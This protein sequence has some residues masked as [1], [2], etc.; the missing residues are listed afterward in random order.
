MRVERGQRPGA[1]PLARSQVTLFC[2]MMPCMGKV[3]AQTAG[4]S[5]DSAKAIHWTTCACASL[6]LPPCSCSLAKENQAMALLSATQAPEDSKRRHLAQGNF[7]R[8]TSLLLVSADKALGNFHFGAQ[9]LG[10]NQRLEARSCPV[11]V[12]FP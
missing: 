11:G 5:S 2:W 4:S 10:G 9:V 7:L 6:A 3:Q 8:R 12:S 1:L